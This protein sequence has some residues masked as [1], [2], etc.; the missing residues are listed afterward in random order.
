MYACLVFLTEY[1]TLLVP[2]KYADASVYMIRN[3]TAKK[4][5]N[6]HCNGEMSR[7]KKVKGTSPHLALLWARWRPRRSSD[8]SPRSAPCLDVTTTLPDKVDTLVKMI[9]SPEYLIATYTTWILHIL[10][11]RIQDFTLEGAHFLAKGLRTA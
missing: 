11:A 2:G 1:N 5:K 4:C 6:I 3:G 10:Q 8:P 7:K 9:A